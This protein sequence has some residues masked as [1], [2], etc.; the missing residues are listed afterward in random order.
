MG[1]QAVS[2]AHSTLARTGPGRQ[3]RVGAQPQE[4]QALAVEGSGS[5]DLVVILLALTHRLLELCG[6]VHDRQV[7]LDGGDQVAA[8]FQALAERS[9]RTGQP[10]A[11]DGH[12]ETDAAALIGLD[13]GQ[14]VELAA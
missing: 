12:Q 4:P 2:A 7:A 3:T 11:E 13:L 5:V 9:E 1:R 14:P 10:L 8:A 6:L